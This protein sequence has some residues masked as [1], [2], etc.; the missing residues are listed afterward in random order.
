MTSAKELQK[1]LTWEFPHSGKAEPA[2]KD[3]AFAYCE[4]YKEFLLHAGAGHEMVGLNLT[5]HRIALV[6]HA[7]YRTVAALH[8]AA[9]VR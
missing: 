4:G 9:S 3:A 1:S 5:Q 8:E 2:A 6:A 7:L